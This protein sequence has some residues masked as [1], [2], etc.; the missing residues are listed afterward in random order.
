M[1]AVGRV[2]SKEYK[3]QKENEISKNPK[4]TTKNTAARRPRTT[5]DSMRKTNPTRQLKL[6]R[7]CRRRVCGNR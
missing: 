4:Q 6:A 2:C 7:V 3:G 5:R 1:R